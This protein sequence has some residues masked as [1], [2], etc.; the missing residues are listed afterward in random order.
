M[1]SL[2]LD[3]TIDGSAKLGIRERRRFAFR[4]LEAASKVIL[5]CYRKLSGL[6]LNREVKFEL[7]NLLQA[8]FERWRYSFASPRFC[9][10][11]Q[12]DHSIGMTKPRRPEKNDDGAG[13]RTLAPHP[14]ASLQTQQVSCLLKGAPFDTAC[15]S[16]TSIQSKPSQ[17]QI[18]EPVPGL[19]LSISIPNVHKS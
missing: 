18:L 11:A 6:W 12:P 3:R 13:Q 8:T 1:R 2:S 19:D 7:G 14:G 15:I 4:S 5:K 9:N 16:D 17:H 10:F